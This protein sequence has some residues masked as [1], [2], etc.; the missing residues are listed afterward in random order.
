MRIGAIV[1]ARTSSARLPGKVLRETAGR[2]LIDFVLARLDRVEGLDGT[3]VATSTEPDDDALA[4]WC[5]SRGV[6]VGRGSL[7]DVLGRVLAIAEDAGFEAL[8]RV[9]A[10]SPWIDPALVSAAAERMRRAPVDLVTNVL[11]R[12]WPYG[13]AVEVALTASL[14]QIW[15][16]GEDA[17][18]RE[19]VTAAFYRDP[20]RF[21]IVN[22][23]APAEAEDPE[24][25][26][27]V[28]EERDLARFE[29]L[30]GELG[31]RAGTAT[32]AEVI[33]AVERIEG[34]IRR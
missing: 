5:R 18:S 25:R 3:I 33:S 21:S 6:A 8:A 22:I 1:L 17:E 13:V 15:E 26:L 10:D 30:V 24:L 19:H 11:E 12:S 32:T 2:P 4:T 9:N 31:E 20:E 7:D 28:D 29:A 23:P 27:T 16:S 14:R 34:A